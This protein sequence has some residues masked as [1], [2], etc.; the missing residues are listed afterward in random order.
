M[1]GSDMFGEFIEILNYI[2]TLFF[3]NK[4]LWLLIPVIIGFG[5]WLVTF[6]VRWFNA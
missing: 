3:I 4:Y 1:T 5:V 2:F 6:I